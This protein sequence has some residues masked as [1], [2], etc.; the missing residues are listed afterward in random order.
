[1]QSHLKHDREL[2]LR[3][4]TAEDATI[5]VGIY[6]LLLNGTAPLSI[7]VG[8]GRTLVYLREGGT[9]LD[10]QK[11]VANET[12]NGLGAVPVHIPAGPVCAGNVSDEIGQRS[13]QI[14]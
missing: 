11:I 5:L 12:A 3:A 9:R 10:G 13:M 2:T 7:P 8:D 4:E 1:M 6:R 14:D